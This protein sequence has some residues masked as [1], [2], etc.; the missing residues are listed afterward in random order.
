MSGIKCPGCGADHNE[1]VMRKE[2]ADIVS[3]DEKG[4]YQNFLET[5]PISDPDPDY[6][7]HTCGMTSK[8]EVKGGVPILVPKHPARKECPNCG[9]CRLVHG[10]PVDLVEPV[11]DMEYTEHGIQDLE[12]DSKQQNYEETVEAMRGRR[13]WC[14]S[15]DFEETRIL[16]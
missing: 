8:R 16:S 11:L 12:T 14:E 5:Q 13:V 6:H 1:I 3:I 9:S 15:C 10:Q 4:D 7:C 2:A